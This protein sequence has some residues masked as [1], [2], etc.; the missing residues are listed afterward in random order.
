VDFSADFH[1]F[2]LEWDEREFRWYIDGRHYQTQ[3]VW[4][5]DRAPYPAPFD[6]R[7]HLLLNLAVGG[8]W[9]GNPD[10][11]SVFPQRMTVDYV[12]VFER[13]TAPAPGQP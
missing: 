5:T 4:S 3:N 13:Q 8:N 2:A 10:A 12:R 1:V 6:Q 9:P 7:F 11:T